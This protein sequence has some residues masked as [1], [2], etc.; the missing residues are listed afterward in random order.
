M[1]LC[2]TC[3]YLY[4]HVFFCVFIFFV[5][6][7]WKQTWI[8]EKANWNAVTLVIMTYLYV[9]LFD[10]FVF[11]FCVVFVFLVNLE[12]KHKFCGKQFEMLQL[13]SSWNIC[14]MQ[15][16]ALTLPPPNNFKWET[17]CYLFLLLPWGEF[18]LFLLPPWREK[19]IKKSFYHHDVNS[20]DREF[21]SQLIFKVGSGLKDCSSAK[22]QS[23]HYM[24]FNESTIYPFYGFRLQQPAFWWRPSPTSSLLLPFHQIL[25]CSLTKHCHPICRII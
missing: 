18:F 23:I 19:F 12:S 15:F 22:A 3:F 13:L 20:L 7:V 6:F 8:L 11:V 21:V 2:S 16:S 9:C 10:R 5:T 24:V 25:F 4:F 17:Y 1:F 14:W